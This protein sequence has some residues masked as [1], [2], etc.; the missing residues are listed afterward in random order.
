MMVRER[1]TRQGEWLGLNR[2]AAYTLNQLRAQIT[3]RLKTEHANAQESLWHR[4]KE[5][6]PIFLSPSLSLV[7][8]SHTHRYPFFFI[9]YPCQMLPSLLHDP[10]PTLCSRCFWRTTTL[11]KHSYC[12]IDSVTCI[13]CSICEIGGTCQQAGYYSITWVGHFHNRGAV[14]V[15]DRS[16]TS[17]Q[18]QVPDRLLYCCGV[19]Y[20]RRNFTHLHG[21]NC[22]CK[23]STTFS[24]LQ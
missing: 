5:W 15:P 20:W 1:I 17:R 22:K 16:I 8:F 7:F 2:A 11:Y 18:F 24:D 19:L 12:S 4:N 21:E 9:S 23:C 6:A 13:Y 3:L 14:I 10:S